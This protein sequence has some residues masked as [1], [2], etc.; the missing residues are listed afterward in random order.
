[1]FD[2]RRDIDVTFL[3]LFVVSTRYVTSVKLLQKPCTLY[4]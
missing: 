2:S 3:V 4:L 1:M